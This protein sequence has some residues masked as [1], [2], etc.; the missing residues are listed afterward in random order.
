MGR[1]S[2]Y[3]FSYFWDFITLSG[4][5]T[6]SSTIEIKYYKKENYLSDS[7]LLDCCF[8][9]V[10]CFNPYFVCGSSLIQN[11]YLTLRDVYISATVVQL[12]TISSA[13]SADESLPT[14]LVD[15]SVI[16][17]KILIHVVLVLCSFIDL[18]S[19]EYENTQLNNSSWVFYEPKTGATSPQSSTSVKA[20]YSE[21]LLQWH[22][23]A[24]VLLMEAGGLNW[25]VGKV[26]SF[27]FI[28]F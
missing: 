27:L 1:R 28:M 25:L 21:T 26:R 19:G 3:F 17:Q 7:L 9:L 10:V 2:F 16:L 20:P 4:Q 22:H 14:S 11:I 13:L 15:K 24:I 12:K 8:L 23:R 18:H 5:F 6:Y